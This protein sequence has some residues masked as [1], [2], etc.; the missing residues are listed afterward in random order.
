M[1]IFFHS[2]G[3]IFNF[4]NNSFPLCDTQHLLEHDRQILMFI[5]GF[6]SPYWVRST[7]AHFEKFPPSLDPLYGST[8]VHASQSAFP[9]IA[10]SS[11][12]GRFSSPITGWPWWDHLS[13]AFGCL[14]LC[15]ICDNGNHINHPVAPRTW[16]SRYPTCRLF[17]RCSHTLNDETGCLITGGWFLQRRYH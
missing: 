5:L 4:P 11:T 9:W 12:F 14:S 7:T 16:P 1:L 13:S 2:C 17:L 3:M 15:H 6:P 10:R 8:V